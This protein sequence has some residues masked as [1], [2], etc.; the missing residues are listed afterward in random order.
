MMNPTPTLSGSHLRTYNKIFQHPFSHTLARRDVRVLLDH[1]AEVVEQPNG[2][3]K[4]T[5]HGEVLVMHPSRTKDLEETE[6][7]A[8]RQFFQRAAKA[9]SSAT[10]DETHRLVVID[11]H[12]ARVFHSQMQG[13]IPEQILPHEPD[14]YF[15]HVHNSKDFA[16]GQEKPDPNSFFEPVAGALKGADKILIFGTGKGSGSEMDQFVAWLRQ[17]HHDLAARIVGTM[18]VDESHLTQDQLL[19][20]ARECYSKASAA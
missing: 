16:R 2:H 14:D 12:V 4:V 15:R 8:L 17:H 20:K 1:V 7:I 5:R 6:I 13:S 10:P 19:A 18:V 11:H 3:L 9:V